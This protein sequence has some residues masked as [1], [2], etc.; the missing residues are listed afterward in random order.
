MIQ[1]NLQNGKRFT[2]LENK[3]GCQGEWIIRKFGM[4]MYT[5]LYLTRL[6]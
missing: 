1:M 3:N 2:D 6:N 4:V 5:R